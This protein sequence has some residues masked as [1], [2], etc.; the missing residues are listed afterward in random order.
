MTNPVD[1]FGNEI[2][3]GSFITYPV[4]GSG[5]SLDVRVGI[6][7]DVEHK[8]NW[9]GRE[10]ISLSVIGIHRNWRYDI[11]NPKRNT[12]VERWEETYH[13]TVTTLKRVIVLNENTLDDLA[14]DRLKEEYNETV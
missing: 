3:V 4:A 7:K 6:V 12:D 14:R 9:R 11:R 10:Y 8:E 13:T 2:K 5:S 1:Y